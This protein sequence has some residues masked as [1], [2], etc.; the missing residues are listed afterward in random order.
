MSGTGELHQHMRLLLGLE[1]WGL[2][3]ERVLL[4][5]MCWALVTQTV[6]SDASLVSLV[7]VAMGSAASMSSTFT[8]AATLLTQVI[9]SVVADVV[10]E[11]TVLVLGQTIAL[12]DGVLFG[13]ILIIV[14]ILIIILL[15]VVLVGAHLSLHRMIASWLSLP[16][17]HLWCLRH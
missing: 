5:V 8:V 11:D 10:S 9:P 7:W 13:S 14:F 1:F 4:P 2:G 6:L 15:I 12:I 16:V 3:V 17:R